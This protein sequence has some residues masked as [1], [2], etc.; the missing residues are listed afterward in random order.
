VPRGLHDL[1]RD[2]AEGDP[3]TVGQVADGVLGLR[4]PPV[5]DP[6]SR[7]RRQLEVTG[8]EVGVEVGVDHTDDV[9][10]VR[11]SVGEVLGDVAARVDDDGLAGR[12]VGDQVGGLRQAVQV[13]LG[14]DHDG[15]SLVVSTAPE[16][17]FRCPYIY[18]S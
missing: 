15:R 18:G 5:A 11:P 6:R 9:Q 2:V 12:L 3:L 4:A 13:V 16:H 7:G 8:E 10:P 14:E 1:E 17:L